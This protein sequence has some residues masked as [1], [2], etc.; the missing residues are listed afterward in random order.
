MTP[1]ELRAKLTKEN[2]ELAELEAHPGWARF[3]EFVGE[4]LTAAQRGNEDLSA[5]PAE[6][7]AYLREKLTLRELSNWL[8]TT[9]QKN[10]EALK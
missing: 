9:R 2:K 1:D 10:K 5:S 4:K 8:A 7:D 6:R 3:M